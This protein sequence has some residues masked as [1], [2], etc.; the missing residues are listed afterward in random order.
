MG[1]INSS[2][3]IAV[4]LYSF[5]TWFVS[6]IY[7]YIPCIKE[8]VSL[9]IIIRTTITMPAQTTTKNCPQIL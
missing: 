9:H 6:G 3:R 1:I 2:N 5:G 4:T 7:V 8:I